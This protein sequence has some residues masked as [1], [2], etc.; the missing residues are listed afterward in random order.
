MIN[1][2]KVLVYGRDKLGVIACDKSSL[3]VYR[4]KTF[5]EQI[6]ARGIAEISFGKSVILKA[7]L[8]C[9]LV[10]AKAVIK[11]S[12]KLLVDSIIIVALVV[13]D[14]KIITN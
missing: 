12:L 13:F 14:T 5:V 8:V 3:R 11:E 2:D 10:A 6:D 1:V 7:F 4:Q 9:F